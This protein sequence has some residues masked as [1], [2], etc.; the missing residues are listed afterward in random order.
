MLWAHRGCVCAAH[1]LL[2][3]FTSGNYSSLSVD[4]LNSKIYTI[5]K[6]PSHWLRPHPVACLRNNLRKRTLDRDYTVFPDFFW[7]VLSS[8]QA[9][10]FVKIDKVA[11][12]TL[13]VKIDKLDLAFWFLPILVSWLDVSVIP[14]TAISKRLLRLHAIYVSLRYCPRIKFSASFLI[15]KS[16]ML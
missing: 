9:T 4:R 8:P 7:L 16:H 3:C 10:L 14:G 13:F 2:I 1:L 6:P 11:Q 15:M 12:A 5:Y